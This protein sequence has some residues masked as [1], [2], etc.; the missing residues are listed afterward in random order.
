[1]NSHTFFTDYLFTSTSGSGNILSFEPNVGTVLF[2]RSG[3]RKNMQMM[4]LGLS[5]THVK[6]LEAAK[7]HDVVIEEHDVIKEQVCNMILLFLTCTD[8]AYFRALH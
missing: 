3:L 8:V 2:F 4:L 7:E 1:M 6:C 5:Y